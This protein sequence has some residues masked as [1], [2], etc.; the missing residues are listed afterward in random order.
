MPDFDVILIGGGAP[1]EH[2]ANVLARGGLRVAIVERELVGGECTHWAC[3]PS[4]TL[5]RSGEALSDA[6]RAPGRARGGHRRPRRRECA[7]LARLHGQQLRRYER[8]RLVEGARDRAAARHRPDRGPGRHRGR[9]RHP[10]HRAHR[11]RHRIRAGDPADRRAARA[12]R[13]MDQPRGHR[14]E[15]CPRA[16]ARAGRRPGGCG[17]GA[18]DRP[19]GELRRAGRG[20]RP[21]AVEG[22]ARG[23]TDA[24]EG[25]RSRGDRVPLRA[26]GE[27]GAAQRQRLRARVPRRQGVARRQAA[28]CDRPQAAGRGRRPRSARHRAG[29][30]RG[31]GRR[32]HGCRQKACGRSAT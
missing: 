23:R 7:R 4:K 22:A 11:D 6:R 10:H 27:A 3:M 24:A 13:R 5:L 14:L 15:G 28:G 9:R 29:E 19:D 1:S 12:R 31:Q 2:C 25:A 21:R 16:P 8:A 20:R 18:G 17:D 30:G 32:P 26:V